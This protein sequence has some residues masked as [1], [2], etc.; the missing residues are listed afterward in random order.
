MTGLDTSKIKAVGVD[1][2]GEERRAVRAV[3]CKTLPSKPRILELYGSGGHMTAFYRASCD[4]PMIVGVDKAP[5][6]DYCMD[7]EKFVQGVLPGLEPF[8]LVDF[9]AYGSPN[10]LIWKALA[11]I[12]LANQ[13][14]VASKFVIVSTDGLGLAMK[15]NPKINWMKYFMIMDPEKDIPDLRRPWDHHIAL[16]EHFFQVLGTV[17]DYKVTCLAAI[18]GKGK[19]FVFSAYQFER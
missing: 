1:H 3:A 11:S 5:G 17:H 18:Q 6:T 15:Q 16:T 9:D 7:N 19:N 12:R 10:P 2:Y 14:T 8:D 4:E 13:G